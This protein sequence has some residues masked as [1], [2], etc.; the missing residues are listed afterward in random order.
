MAEADRMSRWGTDERNIARLVPVVALNRVPPELT[1]WSK[2]VT[3]DSLSTIT[4]TCIA[5]GGQVVPHGI[6]A[7]TMFALT[8]LY[9]MAGRPIDGFITANAI[10][11]CQIIGISRSS[12]IYERV[13]ESLA[14]LVSVKVHVFESWVSIG[15]KGTKSWKTLSFGIIN[16]LETIEF[17]A[18]ADTKPGVFRPTT[19]LRI[20]LS[21]ELVASI[22]SGYVRSVNLDFYSKLDQPLSRLLYR[23]LE[24]QRHDNNMTLDFNLLLSEWANHLGLRNVVR[25]SKNLIVTVKIDKLYDIPD[26]TIFTS[27]RVRR[28]LAPAHE[29]LKQKGYLSKVD[30]VGR[31]QSQRIY[32]KFNDGPTPNPINLELMG[33]L[34]QRGMTPRTAEHT[35]RTHGEDAI[36]HA[37]A[38]FDVRK[39]SGYTIKNAGGLLSDM[40]TNPDKYLLQELPA[41]KV[42]ASKKVK[43]VIEMEV[44]LLVPSMEDIRRTNTFFLEAWVKKNLI[45]PLQLSE[46]L[47]LVRR[48]RLDDVSLSQLAFH[49]LVDVQKFVVERLGNG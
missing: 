7:D 29:E 48:G 43:P 22:K 21:P 44:A 42:A 40:I 37:V 32:Y 33:C 12:R 38:I 45:T 20:G 13:R 30:Y 16:S 1:G 5:G 35:V 34:T 15:T 41:P 10:D 47:V 49:N 17:E 46:L 6:D 18:P 23:T 26:T 14:R 24:E 28:A 2:V 19:V 4:L 27:D 8:A 3:I 31:G 11:L 9:E 39:Q 25:D 36:N